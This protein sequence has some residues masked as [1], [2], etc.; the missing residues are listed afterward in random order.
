[1]C[2]YRITLEQFNDLLVQE[3]VGRYAMSSPLFDLAALKSVTGEEPHSLEVRLEKGWYRNVV[4][5]GKEH[6]IPILTMTC[7]P[8][9][10]EGFKSGELALCAPSKNYANTIVRGLVE[11][12]QLSQE[13]AMSY[14]QEAST[15]AL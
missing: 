3:N 6:N 14:I 9:D 12:E 10:I 7:T 4:C 8:S 11:G 5:L 13:E 1:M 2:L 15:K